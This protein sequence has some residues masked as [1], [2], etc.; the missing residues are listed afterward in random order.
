MLDGLL[1]LVAGEI[2]GER[3]LESVR[4]LARFH[5]VQASPGL[6]D[7]ADWLAAELER[8]GLRVEIEHVPGDGRTRFLGHLMPQGWACERAIATLHGDGA[9]RRLCDYAAQS[10]SL[11]LRSSPGRGRFDLVGIEDGTEPAH[12]DGVDVRGRVV[13]TRGDVHRVHQLA[14]VERGAA[15][16]VSYGRRLLPPVRGEQTDP[17]AIAYTSFWWGEGE[18]RGWGFAISPAEASRIGGRLQDGARL[19]L[20]VEIESRAFDI[21]IP[22]VSARQGVAGPAA[23]DRDEIVIV[24][25]LCHPRP[26]ANDNASGVAANLECARALASLRHA[27]ALPEPLRPIRHLWMPEFTGTYAWLAPRVA[28]GSRRFNAALNLDMVG[29][30]QAQCGSTFLLEHAPCF[31]A[32]FA[33]TL[34]QEI[35][36]KFV[37]PR[38]GSATSAAVGGGTVRMAEAPYSGGSDHTVFLDPAIGVPCPMLIQWPDRYYHSSLDTPDRCD[39]RSLALAASCAAVYAAFIAAAGAAERDFLADRVVS[40]S[41]RRMRDALDHEQA[42]RLAEAELVRGLRALES[43]ER[44]V[45][46]ASDDERIRRESDGLIEFHRREVAAPLAERQS[47]PSASSRAPE[48]HADAAART[49][50]RLLGA[51]LHYQRRLI[52]GWSRLPKEVR[53]RWRAAESP[54]ENLAL[55][56]DLAWSLCDG[57]RDLAAISRLVWL[58]SGRD[59]TES[60]QEFFDWTGALGLSAW[61]S[62]TEA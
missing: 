13:L 14:V 33:E 62:S 22:L 4:A 21:A 8:A 37:N 38:G 58:E 29:E 55:P 46:G 43:L 2:S 56:F 25:H 32:S 20:E 53:E 44:L 35:R 34:L 1:P 61:R 57:R 36:E 42:P 30:D 45:P 5:R 27:G 12:Y 16:L 7:A 11:I 54:P 59:V 51:P 40:R 41:R 26:S 17:D 6:T 50:T 9:P 52:A 24:S 15:G 39:P 28:S 23:T 47:A 60:L 49:P 3:A 18:T 31:A 19:A 48:R 10:L